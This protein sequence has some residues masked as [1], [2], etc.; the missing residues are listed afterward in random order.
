MR[1]TGSMVRVTPRSTAPPVVAVGAVVVDT[2]RRLLVV[3]RGRAPAEGR[4]TL[5]G[6]R[7]EPGEPLRAAL[8]REV[9]EETGVVVDVGDLVGVFEA[10]GPTHHFVILDYAAVLVAGEPAAGDDVVAVRWMGRSELERAG[11]TAGLLEFLA[12]H[13]VDLAP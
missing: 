6:G 8:A 7:V 3:Q 13:G 9:R 12:Q 2:H 11:P 1:Y 4:W 5:P 10:I